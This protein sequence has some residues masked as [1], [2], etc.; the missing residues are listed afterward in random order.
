M[1][2]EKG[3]DFKHGNTEAGIEHTG[4]LYF[5]KYIYMPLLYFMGTSGSI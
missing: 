4:N 3:I 5:A 1:S 2:L